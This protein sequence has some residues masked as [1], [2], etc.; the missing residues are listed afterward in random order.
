[1]LIIPY[2]LRNAGVAVARPRLFQFF[3]LPA[4]DL[5]VS[6]VEVSSANIAYVMLLMKS[7]EFFAV[8]FEQE[9]QLVRTG[10][11]L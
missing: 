1:V 8:D 2:H 4:S 10:A 7:F 11:G 3:T 5:T 6:G 9:L